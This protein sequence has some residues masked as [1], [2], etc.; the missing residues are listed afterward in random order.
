MTDR[1]EGVRLFFSASIP[2]VLK[3][4]PAAERAPALVMDL[5]G[6]LLAGGGT[7]ICGGHPSITPLLDHLVRETGA[8]QGQVEL[9][10]LRRFPRGGSFEALGPFVWHGDGQAPIG[11]ELTAM[12]RAMVAGATAAVFVGGEDTAHSKTNP[13]GLREE[14]ELFRA[15]QPKAPAF[16]SGLLEGYAAEAL[17]PDARAGRIETR[18]GLGEKAR[19]LMWG[20]DSV[21]T[22]AGLALRAL[23]GGVS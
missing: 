10:Q 8:A 21:E 4:H 23:G 14:F 20:T 15:A 9:H 22:F 19:A 12:R 7:V 5:I 13:P 11:E 2:T 16:L 3:D 6:G 18:D 17:I 1:F